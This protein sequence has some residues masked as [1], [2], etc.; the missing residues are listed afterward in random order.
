M[1][2]SPTAFLVVLGVT[3]LA[4]FASTS[5]TNAAVLGAVPVAMRA[6]AM[7][8]SIFAIHL[9]GDLLSPN[10]VGAVSDAFHDA[11]GECTGARGLVIGMYLLPAALALS[12]LAW[13]R[14]AAAPRVTPPGTA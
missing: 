1:Q 8:A 4:I 10:A 2:G 5:P 3:E 13:F 6:N 11:Q 12:A 7:A 9:L 14:G